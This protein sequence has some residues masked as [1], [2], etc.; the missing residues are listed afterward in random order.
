LPTLSRS[1]SEQTRSTCSPNSRLSRP[2]PGTT[3]TPPGSHGDFLQSPEHSLQARVRASDSTRS[4]S[5]YRSVSSAA[6]HSSQNPVASTVASRMAQR[7]QSSV[8]SIS[9]GTI[10]VDTGGRTWRASLVSRLDAAVWQCQGGP[11]ALG[12]GPRQ[13]RP[14][15]GVE[16]LKST[17]HR[18]IVRRGEATGPS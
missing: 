9:R 8:V 11:S 4:R 1:R 12:T 18:R 5:L 16:S 15:K 2:R 7:G 6:V 3:H 13:D 17:L 14:G 10:P